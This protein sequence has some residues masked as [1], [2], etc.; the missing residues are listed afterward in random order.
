MSDFRDELKER[1]LQAAHRVQAGIA[2]LIG[3]GD[4][5]YRGAESKHLRVGIDIS[6]AEQEGLA[7]LLIQKGVITEAEYLRAMTEAVEKEAAE[8]ETRVQEAFGNPNIKLG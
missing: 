4:I 3:L 2:A 6:K 7:S 5:R 8:F 1:Y